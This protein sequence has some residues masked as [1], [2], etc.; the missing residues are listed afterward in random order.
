MVEICSGEKFEKLCGS[1]SLDIFDFTRA[2]SERINA[3]RNALNYEQPG[4]DMFH[5]AKCF[6]SVIWFDIPDPNNPFMVIGNLESLYVVNISLKI[7]EFF[8]GFFKK[9]K[10]V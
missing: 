1:D 2:I 9:F 10:I 7:F 5:L 4:P 6:L 8:N 3:Y